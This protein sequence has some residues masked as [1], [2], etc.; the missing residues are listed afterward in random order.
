MTK[1]GAAAKSNRSKRRK[2]AEP[3][4]AD[5]DFYEIRDIVGEKRV[6]GKL[7][8]KVDWADNPITGQRYDPSW[9]CT[10]RLNPDSVGW[11]PGSY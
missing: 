1:Q 8:Y 5:E 10:C 11:A 3:A 2:Q 9:V 6:K 4:P 7:L